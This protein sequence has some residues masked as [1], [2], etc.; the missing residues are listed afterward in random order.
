MCLSSSKKACHLSKNIY[1]RTFKD[2]ANGYWNPQVVFPLLKK[3]TQKLQGAW[4]SLGKKTLFGSAA[5]SVCSSG[6]SQVSSKTSYTMTC[7]LLKLQVF[8]N[9]FFPWFQSTA[10]SLMRWNSLFFQSKLPHFIFGASFLLT[11]GQPSLWLIWI[12][13]QSQ[14]SSHLYSPDKCSW[15]TKSQPYLYLNRFRADEVKS[16]QRTFK[17]IWL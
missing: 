5:I 12:F 15:V 4:V 16:S 6:R 8:C 13:S 7:N 2:F 17:D 9:N 1:P 11:Q 14:P 3:E 10:W